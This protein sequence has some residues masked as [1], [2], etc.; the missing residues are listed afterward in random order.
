MLDFVFNTFFV[1]VVLLLALR[2]L[3]VWD[4]HQ[5]FV[6][7]MLARTA[8][9]NC[10]ET[11]GKEAAEAARLKFRAAVIASRNAHPPGTRI[12]F[13]RF[14]R[15]RCPHCGAPAKFNYEKRMF[16]EDVPVPFEGNLPVADVDVA[17]DIEDRPTK[18]GCLVYGIMIGVLIAGFGAETLAPE[19]RFGEFVS[20]ETGKWI[21][22]GAVAVITVVVHMVLS[23]AG[24]ET[25]RSKDG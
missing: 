17:L 10:G 3:R 13:V 6:A 15:V 11:Y 8:C 14:W 1:L 22:A 20:T 24:I 16:Q 4:L 25:W 5:M 23:R 19:S 21:W 9:R 2:V 18:A 7:S 12:N